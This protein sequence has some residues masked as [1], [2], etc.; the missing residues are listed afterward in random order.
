MAIY[1]TYTM[2]SVPSTAPNMKALLGQKYKHSNPQIK[3]SDA[4]QE[5]DEDSTDEMLDSEVIS[6]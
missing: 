3:I 5:N 1:N 2:Q 4:E 6:H